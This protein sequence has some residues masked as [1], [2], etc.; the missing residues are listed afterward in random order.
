[1]RLKTCDG[2]KSVLG[3]LGAL[4]VWLSLAR[5]PRVDV[6]DARTVPQFSILG[7]GLRTPS[8]TAGEPTDVWS[9]YG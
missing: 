6:E 3:Y 1:M 2:L 9:V 7:P 5:L 8:E 4:L